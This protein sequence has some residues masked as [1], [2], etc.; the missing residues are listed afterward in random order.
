MKRGRKSQAELAALA[1]RPADFR[2]P[3]QIEQ[4]ACCGCKGSDD[5][6]A[7]QNENAPWRYGLGGSPPPTDLQQAERRIRELAADVETY[8]LQ[9]QTDR[10][11]IAS[12]QSQLSKREGEVERLKG[13]VRQLKHAL[14]DCHV[15]GGH[16]TIEHAA[17]TT[18]ANQHSA[19][20][21]RCDHCDGLGVEL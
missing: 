18:G 3:W 4:A 17:K 13:D 11:T 6:C 19:G 1:K 21:E 12:L 8:R 20:A 9:Q 14:P 2:E 16:G 7:C 15:C 5:L 10:Q